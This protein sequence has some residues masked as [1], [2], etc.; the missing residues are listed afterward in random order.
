MPKNSPDPAAPADSPVD[1][2]TQLIPAVRSGVPQHDQT[3]LIPPVPSTA[4]RPGS[5]GGSEMDHTAV[6]PVVPP[7]SDVT[8]VERPQRIPRKD[9]TGFIMFGRVRAYDSEPGAVGYRGRHGDI[10]PLAEASRTRKIFH[11]VGEVMITFGLVLL[12]FAGYEIWGKAA[13]VEDHQNDLDSQLEQAWADDPTVVVVPPPVDP[14]A[15]PTPSPTKA[16]PPPI[17]PGGS[18]GRLYLPRLGKYWVV[19]EGIEPQDI[20][21]APGHYPD[22]ALPG[23]VGNFSVAGHRSPAIFWDLDRMRAGD[24]VVVETRTTYFVYRV[25]SLQ[26]VAPTATEVVAPV[27]GQPG[28]VAQCSDVD[29]D[30]VQPQVGQLPAADHARTAR[31]QPAPL[32]RAPG[33]NRRIGGTHVRLDL[34][35]ASLRCA[36]QAGRVSSAGRHHGRHTVVLDLPGRRATAPVR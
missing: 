23:E 7:A 29:L 21:Y 6:I 26:I 36:R 24:P 14:S 13:I 34:A 31:T 30:H 3:Q 32:R 22:T 19:V 5:A 8:Q 2:A 12:L 9:D 16:A 11:G 33:R 20:E 35:Q 28:V 1:D 4:P 18:L 25:T 15:G 27:P 17:P 10:I